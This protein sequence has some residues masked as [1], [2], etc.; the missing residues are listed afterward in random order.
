MQNP[1][2]K[3]E[4]ELANPSSEQSLKL[5]TELLRLLTDM[6]LNVRINE[7]ALSYTHAFCTSY[8]PRKV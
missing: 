4:I 6:G 1:P 8:E 3:L 2:L 5:R 7:T